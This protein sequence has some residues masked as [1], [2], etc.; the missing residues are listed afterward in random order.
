M[1]NYI[2]NMSLLVWSI[3][4]SFS[5]VLLFKYIPK[6]V[7]ML[8]DN[9]SNNCQLTAAIS[10]LQKEQDEISIVREFAKHAKLQRKINKLT[11]EL[12][13][14]VRNNMTKKFKMKFI[15]NILL[16]VLSGVSNVL[17]VSYN[18]RRAVVS[19]LPDWFS[20]VSWL[21]QWPLTEA[22]TMSFFF[23]FGV[24]NCVARL[25]TNSVLL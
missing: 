25:A 20:P 12:K 22:G 11:E 6:I 19:E 15:C 10:S 7:S 3:L 17:F 2:V 4:I 24:T 16:Y 14:Q 5:N 13:S 1:L 18:Y 9:N 8:L 23:W 21:I